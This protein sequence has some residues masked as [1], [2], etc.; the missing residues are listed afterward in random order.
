[1]ECRH[2]VEAIEQDLD[3]SRDHEREGQDRDQRTPQVAAEDAFGAL[4]VALQ[5]EEHLAQTAG[6]VQPEHR[7]EEDHVHGVVEER[8]VDQ[9]QKE[10]QDPHQREGLGIDSERIRQNAGRDQQ[11]QKGVRG[12]VPLKTSVPVLLVPRPSNSQRPNKR[13]IPIPASSS[14]PAGASLA[15]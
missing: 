10:H 5:G 1:M 11:V 4:S 8:A 6:T 12:E 9:Q 7:D 15:L 14:A 3:G 13:I 2:E